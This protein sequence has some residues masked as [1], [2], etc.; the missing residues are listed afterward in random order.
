MLTLAELSDKLTAILDQGD[1]TDE[2]LLGY[3]IVVLHATGYNDP[4]TKLI[5]YGKVMLHFNAE[6]WTCRTPLC[7]LGVTIA[8]IIKGLL[9]CIEKGGKPYNTRRVLNH[10]VGLYSSFDLYKGVNLG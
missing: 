10:A 7:D 5:S 2:E 8:N 1:T 6:A 9:T 4:S 3:L